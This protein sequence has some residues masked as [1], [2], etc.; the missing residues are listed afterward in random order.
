[1]DLRI[2]EIAS[3]TENNRFLTNTHINQKIKIQCVVMKWKLVF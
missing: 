2:L 3:N 1:M